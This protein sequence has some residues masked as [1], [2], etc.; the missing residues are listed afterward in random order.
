MR[1]IWFATGKSNTGEVISVS[2][3]RR[4]RADP[5]CG[6]HADMCA[7]GLRLNKPAMTVPML[8]KPDSSPEV[9]VNDLSGMAV[10]KMPEI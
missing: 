5:G 10:L 8:A 3:R 9:C 7:S 4:E 1:R 6:H 2:S